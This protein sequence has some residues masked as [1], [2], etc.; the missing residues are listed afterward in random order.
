MAVEAVTFEMVRQARERIASHI[1]R[2]PLVR[3]STL[4]EV[5]RTNVYL[6]LELFQRTGAFKVRGA[7]NRILALTEK[8]KGV[9]TVSAGNHGQAVAYAA[10]RTG[11][12][13][14][15]MLPQGTPQNYVDATRAYG[16]EVRFVANLREGFSAAA[17]YQS[18]GFT[19]V[20]PYGDPLVVAGQGTLALEICDQLPEL[21]DVFVSIGGGGLAAGTAVAVKGLNPSIRVWGVETKGADCMSQALRAGSI[22][23]MREITSRARTLGAPSAAPLTFEIVRE[24]VEEVVVV[25]DEEAERDSLFLLERAKVLTELAASC[26]LSALRSR[27]GRFMQDDHV[28][29]VLCGGNADLA[30][31]FVP[32]AVAGQAA[33]AQRSAQ[34][35]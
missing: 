15:I 12:P 22:V 24:L 11:T 32:P 34:R 8:P 35:I 20:H 33:F 30:Q 9:V 17:A 18:S 31:M 28:A 3:S 26:T 29:L 19:F 25:D 14:I 10:L 27:A 21:T 16:A 13:A 4:S 6:K 23:S 7:L 1:H 2:T 5:F